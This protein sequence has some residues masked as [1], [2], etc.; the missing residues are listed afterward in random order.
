MGTYNHAPSRLWGYQTR[1]PT[2]D[3][4]HTGSSSFFPNT[5]LRSLNCQ[6]LMRAELWEPHIG[7]QNLLQLGYV[8]WHTAPAAQVHWSHGTHLANLKCQNSTRS[9]KSK[10]NKTPVKR[11]R[12]LCSRWIMA[13]RDLNPQHFDFFYFNLYLTFSC[14]SSKYRLRVSFFYPRDVRTFSPFQNVTVTQQYI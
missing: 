5:D 7:N 9:R 12:G 13:A 2:L 6:T 1:S 3:Q 11:T 14:V 8:H 10:N 4:A